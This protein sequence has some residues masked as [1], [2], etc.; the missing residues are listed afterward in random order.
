MLT[1]P[2]G[3]VFRKMYCYQCGIRL[4]KEKISNVYKKGETGYTRHLPGRFGGIPLGMS[5]LEKVGYCYQCPSCK[6]TFT[7]DEQCIIAKKQKKLKKIILAEEEL[8]V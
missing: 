6:F 1:I 4:K 7:Y 2:V 5:E 8:E 3:M